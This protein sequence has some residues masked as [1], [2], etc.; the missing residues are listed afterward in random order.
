MNS[1]TK[2][3]AN[4]AL[5]QTVLKTNNLFVFTLAAH[6]QGDQASPGIFWGW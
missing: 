4:Y 2:R 6:H 5:K 1:K 3:S